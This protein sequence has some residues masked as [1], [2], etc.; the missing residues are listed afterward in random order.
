M[1]IEPDFKTYQSLAK[2]APY[3][4]VWTEILADTE[5]PISLYLKLGNSSNSFLLESV[6]G[7]ERLGRYSIIG[8]NPLL[9]F[10]TINGKAYTVTVGQEKELTEKP[11]D[12]LYKLINQLSLPPITEPRFLG[13]LVGFLGYD[14]VRE[15]ENL[16]EHENDD[17]EL[18]STYLTLHQELLIYDHVKRT[19]RVA[20][21]G[22]GGEMTKD[23]YEKAVE[24]VKEIV[25]KISTPMVTE[26]VNSE[27]SLI[28]SWEANLTRKEF[29]ERVEKAKEYIAAGDIFQVVLSQRFNS[30]YK[31]DP[32]VIYRQLRA[33]NPSPYMFYL[34]YPEVQ[35]VGASPEMLV[36]VENGV[37]NYRPIAGTRPR[38]HSEAEDRALA[39]ELSNDEK[40][41]AEHLML[42]DLG[43][44]DVGKVAVP[45]SI[46]IPEQMV[47]EYYSHVMHLVSSITGR[48][49]PGKNALDALLACFPAGT[50]TGA[51]KVRAMEIIAELE[52][53]ARGPYSGAVGYFS[54]HGNL[55]TCIT[56]RNIVFTSGQAFVQVGAG[57]VA[58]SDPAREYDETI[59]KARALFRVLSGQEVKLCS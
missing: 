7:G 1:V 6:E 38:G 50:V 51:P 22:R 18:P 24:K 15:L 8:Y 25:K 36:Q 48:L 10:K 58:D 37:I 47:V 55:D 3:V 33:L 13:G 32:L 45:G 20:Y 9:T 4:P 39:Q 59:N 44:N 57:I 28:G 35:L 42:L 30:P 43:R 23:G 52:K 56:I 17:L 11:L 53:V 40:E 14:L 21:L 19:V 34:N 49:A 12:A 31:G 5:T 29:M 41:R 54:L 2:D 26:K 16:P 27:F 46:Q